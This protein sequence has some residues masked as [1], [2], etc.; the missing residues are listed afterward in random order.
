MHVHD[1][2]PSKKATR[3]CMR[4]GGSLTT[5]Y[6]GGQSLFRITLGRVLMPFPSQKYVDSMVIVVRTE[7]L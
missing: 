6:Q 2:G 1:L 5:R 4:E 3:V 7:K